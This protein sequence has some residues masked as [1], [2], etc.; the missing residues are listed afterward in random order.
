MLNYGRW[1]TVTRHGDFTVGKMPCKLEGKWMIGF[2]L[3][4]QELG[5]FVLYR[6]STICGLAGVANCNL[7][8]EEDTNI[9]LVGGSIPCSSLWR[10]R[11]F[12]G[13]ARVNFSFRTRCTWIALELS[14]QKLPFD[15]W[16]NMENNIQEKHG[17]KTILYWNS[18]PFGNAGD[19]ICF[20][21]AWKILVW[22]DADSAKKNS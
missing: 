5:P 18:N 22:R 15:V 14:P 16:K 17:R 13:T 2:C 1:P 12:H 9:R 10:P 11:R 21:F 20:R 19:G 8:M 4:Y 3:F 6:A 7:W